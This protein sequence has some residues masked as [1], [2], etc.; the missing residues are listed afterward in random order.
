LI[1]IRERWRSLS[2]RFI[3]YDSFQLGKTYRPPV[4]DK[5]TGSLLSPILTASMVKVDVGG[6]R[7]GGKDGGNCL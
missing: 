4:G 5:T 6:E 7:R 2:E 1:F 3:F